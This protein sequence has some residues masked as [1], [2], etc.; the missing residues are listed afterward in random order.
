MKARSRARPGLRGVRN[1]A[2]YIAAG[3]AAES[4]FVV[5]VVV[6]SV[7]AESVTAGVVASAGVV[8]S[9]LGAQAAN[10]TTAARRARR[11]ILGKSPK[12]VGAGT[13][14]LFALA[15]LRGEITVGILPGQRR[16]SLINKW[17]RQAPS[18]RSGWVLCKRNP[19]NDLHHLPVPPP[20]AVGAAPTR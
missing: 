3:A 11:F 8:S 5:S 15:A 7:V 14:D 1:D 20:E 19:D 6:E 2:A 17:L 4:V 13:R 12:I 16:K 18:G 9:A 10:S